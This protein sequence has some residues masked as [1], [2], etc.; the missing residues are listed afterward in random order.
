MSD[1]ARHLGWLLSAVAGKTV[2]VEF[3]DYVTPTN[4]ARP[5]SDIKKLSLISTL[6]SKPVESKSAKP[7]TQQAQPAHGR[8]K[9]REAKAD[10]V[11]VVSGANWEAVKTFFKQFG[12]AVPPEVEFRGPLTSKDIEVKLELRWKRRKTN[13][14]ERVLETLARALDSATD[15]DYEMEFNDKTWRKGRDL[16]LVKDLKIIYIDGI[17]QPSSAYAVMLVWLQELI[18]SRKVS[19]KV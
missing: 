10:L 8:K 6:E 3:V 5:V 14:R 4:A 13:E 11:N 1:L 15:L 19:S 18:A 17:P 2:S 16:K 9:E 12:A 7:T